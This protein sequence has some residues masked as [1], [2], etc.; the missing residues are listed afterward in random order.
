VDGESPLLVLL[1]PARLEAFELR[2]HA[3]GLLRSPAA[4][5]VEPGRVGIGALPPGIVDGLAHGQAK[6]MRLPGVPTAFVLYHPRQYPLARALLGRH[7]GAELWYGRPADAA[8]DGGDRM[9]ELHLHA[10]RRAALTFEA[11]GDP[12]PLLERF[13]D[14]ATGGVGN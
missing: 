14:M 9:Q 12:R 10:V 8:V 11:P 6:R 5:A 4:V 7:P 2:E 13:A 3:E 1:L